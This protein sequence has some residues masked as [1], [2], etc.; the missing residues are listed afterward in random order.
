M[1]DYIPPNDAEFNTWQTNFLDYV[2]ANL[3]ALGLEHADA[4]PLEAARTNWATAYTAHV[5][6]QATAQGASQTKKSARESYE[7][8]LRVLVKRLQSQPNVSD[9]HRAGMRVSIH[10]TTRTPLGAPETRPVATIDTNQRL[11]HTINF[12]DETTPSR[13]AKPAGVLGCEVYVKVGDPAPIDPSELKFLATDTATPYVAIYDGA[14]GGKT[15]HYMLRWV[16][17]KGETGPWSQT[18]SATITG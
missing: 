18:V 11:R 3:T 4:A 8:L 14:N 9:A 1:A 12:S 5:A 17:R 10:E 15:A 7:Q 2:N 16:N 6:A 13:R